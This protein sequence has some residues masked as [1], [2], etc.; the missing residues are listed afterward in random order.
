MTS[1]ALRIRDD[2]RHYRY[3]RPVLSDI[4]RI[5]DE[6]SASVLARPIQ[7]CL[8][9]PTAQN[10]RCCAPRRLFFEINPTR[11]VSGDACAVFGRRSPMRA[12]TA[13]AS[14]AKG[15]LNRRKP[16]QPGFLHVSRDTVCVIAD[17]PWCLAKSSAAP[18]SSCKPPFCPVLHRLP[19]A[20]IAIGKIA[21]QNRI[22]LSGH[23]QS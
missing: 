22:A 20:T 18:T 1:A 10:L 4:S 11:W 19:I 12:S 23:I 2:Y 17:R 16:F 15:C 5:A 14:N 8:S 9:S 21:R 6:L 7:R 3:Y 13:K